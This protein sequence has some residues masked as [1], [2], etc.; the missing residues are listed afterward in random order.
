[1][2]ILKKKKNLAEVEEEADQRTEGVFREEGE[3]FCS[4]FLLISFNL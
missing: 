2:T 3:E 1:L 4:C